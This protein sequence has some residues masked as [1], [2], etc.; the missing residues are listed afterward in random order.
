MAGIFI[1]Y[2][3]DDSA[4]WTGRLAT[5]LQ[6]RFGREVVFQDIGTIGAGEDFLEIIKRFLESCSAVLVVIGPD[7]SV[8]KDNK[9]VRRLDDPKDTV[10]TE[11]AQALQQ[12]DRLVIPVLVGGAKMPTPDELPEE[13]KA[14]ARRNAFDLS[15]KRWEYDLEQL[16]AN[17]V[18]KTG[19]IQ[20]PPITPPLPSS[21]PRS[22]WW[23]ATLVG[24]V[25]LA[26]VGYFVY[27]QLLFC[28][29]GSGQVYIQYTDQSLKDK[30]KALRDT[31]NK[32]GYYAPDPE[33][34]PQRLSATEIRY[35]STS[36]I[37]Q[38]EILACILKKQGYSPILNPVQGYSQNSPLEVW[39]S[40]GD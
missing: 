19:P 37:S 24:C 21:R 31:L 8:V 40:K 34:T 25:M 11:I 3:R 23:S 28:G 32:T 15:D 4:G 30:A 9:G 17:L 12:K 22:L 39:L 36:Q 20:E 7:W 16:V 13:L 14:L 29:Q 26:I 2:R 10:R 1:S 27:S 18:K 5:D 35:F 38:A 6:K 33:F